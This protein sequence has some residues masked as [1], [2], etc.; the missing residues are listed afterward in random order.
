M[1]ILVI[2]FVPCFLL[3]FF[4]IICSFTTNIYLLIILII[5]IYN[6]VILFV[7][8]AKLGKGFS[9]W[10]LSYLKDLIKVMKK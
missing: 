9:N 5:M 10:F 3:V 4:F 6:A 8:D 2:L 1:G 7:V